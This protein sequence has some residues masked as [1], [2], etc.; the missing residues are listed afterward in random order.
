[1]RLRTLSGSRLGRR[2]GAAAVEFAIVLP[3]LAILLLG[4][5]ETS[6]FIAVSELLAN[7]ARDGC[8]DAVINGNTN[9]TATAR[10]AAMLSNAGIPTSY[11]TI[12]IQQNV[13]TTALGD[14]ITVTV[15]VPYGKVSWSPAPYVLSPNLTL[16]GTATMS[17]EQNPPP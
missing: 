5:L 13:Q 15:T 12:T 2:D 3:F 1:M 4:T 11:T 16:S 10:M 8:R 6:R 7:V 17:S 9:A 14:P